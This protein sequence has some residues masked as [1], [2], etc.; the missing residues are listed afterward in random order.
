MVIGVAN[1]VTAAVGDDRTGIR[2]IP[3]LRDSVK[4]AALQ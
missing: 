4:I 1:I 3:D 2:R